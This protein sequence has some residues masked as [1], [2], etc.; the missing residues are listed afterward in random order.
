[1]RKSHAVCLAVAASL[2]FLNAA[3]RA[4]TL[5]NSDGFEASIGFEPGVLNGQSA[6]SQP[7]WKVRTTA[8]AAAGASSAVVENS[9]VYQGAQAVQFTRALGDRDTYYAP[10]A[11]PVLPG[12]P[13]STQYLNI[14]WDME[15]LSGAEEDPFFG[16]FAFNGSAR[17]GYAGIDASTGQ[18]QYSQAGT[19]GL[20]T[21]GTTVA[22]N[23][24]NTFDLQLNYAT[25][26]ET[27]FVNGTAVASSGFISSSPQNSFTDADIASFASNTQQTGAGTV[28]FDNYI[29][30]TSNSGYNPPANLTWNNA[31]A[32]G[33]GTTWDVGNSQNFNNGVT[34]AAFNNGDNVLFSDSNNGHYNVTINSVVSPG[35]LTVTNSAGNYTFS[36]TGGITGLT[37]LT[38]NGTGSLTLS[39]SNTYSGDTIVNAGTLIL[40]SSRAFPA[41]TNLTIASS[42]I[43]TVAN[44]AARPVLVVDIH[45][46]AN[47]G[48]VDITNND[49]IVESPSELATI[50]S[51]V[52]QGYNLGGWNGGVGITSSVAAA[53]SAHITAVGVIANDNG[54]GAP[55]YGSGGSLGFFDGA[56]PAD[57]DVLV[58]YTYFGDTN[59]DGKVDG[60]DY[61]R[62][63][64]GAL[65]HLT[66]WYNGDFNYDGVVNGSDYTLI[67]NAFNTQGASLSDSL[68][69]PSAEVTA[70]ISAVP[71]PSQLMLLAAFGALVASPLGRRRNRS[72]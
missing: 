13:L 56:S 22:L 14:S 53:D 40:A 38:K 31:G 17:L 23:Q 45:S 21:S 43:V 19:A 41:D 9:N 5:Y 25:Q 26:S 33:D 24:W 32:S 20:I 36:G 58:K 10:V 44:H 69:G 57:G 55:L 1:M 16:I 46:L 72:I 12:A 52:A 59:L 50:N 35:S 61:S 34:P 54:T 66:G 70:E 71:E 11:T 3:G 2:T 42:G 68:N 39:T 62:V 6:G 60:T 8:V 37:G 48:L 51:E 4:D 18:V 64:N 28:Y 47:S 67:D 27:I 29:V 30:S 65:N 7:S 63:D 49:L 15:A